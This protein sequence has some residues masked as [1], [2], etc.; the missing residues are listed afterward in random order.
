[1]GTAK[2]PGL[3]Q[4]AA[5][6]LSAKLVGFVLT[7]AIP[8][9]VVRVL[10]QREFGLYKQAFLFIATVADL[11]PMGFYM[12]AFYFLPKI[13]DRGGAIVLNILI[14]NAFVG[15]V[16]LVLLWIHP[17]ILNALL[18]NSDLVPLAPLIGAVVLTTIVAYFVEI[19][20]TAREQARQSSALIVFAS[21]TRGAAM[22]AAVVI[23]K[24]VQSL[25]YAAVLQGAVVSCVLVIY[26]H[27]QFPYFWQR[28]DASLMRQQLAYALPIGFAG[29]PILVQHQLHFYIVAQR[30]SAA[31]YAIYAVGCFQLPAISLLRESVTS[32]LIPRMVHLR[33]AD[34]RHG[35]TILLASA[36]RKLA[37][38]HWP[39]FGFLV[40]SGPIFIQLVFTPQYAESWPIF[41]VNLMMIPLTVLISDPV[42]RAYPEQTGF[43]LRAR[44]ACA[45]LLLP[46]LYLG[47]TVW[48]MTGAITATVLSMTA[49]RVVVMLRLMRLLGIRNSGLKEFRAIAQFGFVAGAAGIGASFVLMATRSESLL[50]SFVASAVIYGAT[51]A[52]G[53][54]FFGLLTSQEI[55]SVRALIHRLYK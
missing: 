52:A 5:W 41:L 42:L 8:L 14:V 55:S 49:E 29:F 51:Y 4:Q 50:L 17:G 32:V 36:M 40:V 39:I 9:L 19:V 28:W 7:V 45:L 10:D 22:V 11:L 24:D 31:E 38:I 44:F 1:M 30:L 48:G 46:A 54:G 21:A 25:L 2:S 26:L 13:P 18:G 12:S 53:V 23:F 33:Q 20:A 34:D 27:R 16:A 35:I 43:V 15:S 3:S 47:V 37:L 6:L